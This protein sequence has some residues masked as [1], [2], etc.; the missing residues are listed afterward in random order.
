MR[1][2]QLSGTELYHLSVVAMEVMT[3]RH[4]DL[5]NVHLEVLHSLAPKGARIL[6]IIS[7]QHQCA[8]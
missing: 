2:Q 8:V 5:I 4:V 1:I 3:S 7:S 6:A